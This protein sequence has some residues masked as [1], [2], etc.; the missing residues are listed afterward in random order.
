[1][2]LKINIKSFIKRAVNSSGQPYLELGV[3][4][5]A[6]IPQTYRL[7]I[8]NDEIYMVYGSGDSEDLLPLTRWYS[9][10]GKSSFEVNTLLTQQEMAI[11]PFRFIKNDDGSLSFRKVE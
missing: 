4:P 9:K 1:L 6:S 7:R 2:Y 5:N 3:Q 11:E 10:D 8:E